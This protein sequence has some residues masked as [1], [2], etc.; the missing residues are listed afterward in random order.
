MMPTAPLLQ[1]K[2]PVVGPSR[3]LR[4]SGTSWTLT[5]RFCRFV[6]VSIHCQLAVL[7]L[8]VLGQSGRHVLIRPSSQLDY[9]LPCITYNYVQNLDLFLS[10]SRARR[11]LL[12]MMLPSPA[13]ASLDICLTLILS[14]TPRA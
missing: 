12:A 4:P 2:W 7:A 1:A 13:A 9:L 8:P 10:C 5:A 11:L 3:I 14:K 6:L